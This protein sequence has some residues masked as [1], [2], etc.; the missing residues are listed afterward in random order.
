MFTDLKH[1]ESIDPHRLERA[2]V[3]AR[4]HL[5]ASIGRT[6]LWRGGSGIQFIRHGCV[7]LVDVVWWGRY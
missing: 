6:K 7:G 1:N 5:A 2:R 3:T 4:L